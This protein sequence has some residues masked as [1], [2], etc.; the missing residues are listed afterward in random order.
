MP[1]QINGMLL[2]SS[3]IIYLNI[4]YT[5]VYRWVRSFWYVERKNDFHFDMYSFEFI[6]HV[7]YY[8]QWPVHVDYYHYRFQISL[9]RLQSSL[10]SCP[11]E[12]VHLTN[13]PDNKVT[14]SGCQ[15][16]LHYLLQAARIHPRQRVAQFMNDAL[17][18][19]K[20]KQEPGGAQVERAYTGY[21][22]DLETSCKFW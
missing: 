17:A 13:G 5:L 22:E 2:C 19:G 1:L 16:G 3:I 7:K 10:S 21:D 8:L 12:L 18:G 15:I 4:W 9:F 14:T 6:D 20:V 11:L